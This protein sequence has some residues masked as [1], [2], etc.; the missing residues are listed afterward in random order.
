M[1]SD[2]NSFKFLQAGPYKGLSGD[3]YSDILR[4]CHIS[5]EYFLKKKHESEIG[6]FLYTCW[7]IMCPFQVNARGQ[8]NTVIWNVT[9][10]SLNLAYTYGLTFGNRK[11]PKNLVLSMTYP[12]I[13]LHIPVTNKAN[14]STK[15]PQ[16]T[17][18]VQSGTH[19]K[20]SQ[21]YICCQD[22]ESDGVVQQ[23][24]QHQLLECYIDILRQVDMT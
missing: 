5:D 21:A 12:Q 23:P 24:G 20:T 16:K 9:Q 1:T 8:S 3:L 6:I 11:T 22:K 13:G 2:Q 7:D 10:D 15:H 14:T 17:S 4:Y 18:W 19:M